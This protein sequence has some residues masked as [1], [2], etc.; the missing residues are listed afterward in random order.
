MPTLDNR[1]YMWY[2]NHPMLGLNPKVV[3]Y[4]KRRGAAI[5][6]VDNQN[7]CMSCMSILELL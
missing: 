1:K 3:V 6:I 4:L 2:A 5:G 7:S